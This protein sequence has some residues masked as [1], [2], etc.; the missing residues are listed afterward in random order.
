MVACGIVKKTDVKG[1]RCS[2]CEK[3]AAVFLPYA[4]TYLCRAHFF[5]HF[6]KA[7]FGTL[8]EFAMIKKG[9]KVAIGL[10]GGKDSVVLLSMLALLRKKLPYE[11]FAITMNLGI[12]C[13]Y[14][15]ETIRIAKEECARLGVRHYLFSL[16]DDFGYTLDEI[17]EKTG[18]RNPCS[19]CG[20][21]KRYLLNKHARE[22]GATK[23]AIAHTLNDTAETVMMNILRNEPLRLFRYNVHLVKDEK[24]V[25]RLKPFFRIPEDEVIAYGMLKN[26]PLLEKKCCPYSVFAFRKF[27]RRQLEDL[28][29]R[30]PGT[31]FRI[32]NSFLAMQKLFRL[33]G[34]KFRIK[35][36]VQCGEPSSSERC[37]FCII[38]EKLA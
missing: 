14:N 24:F 11:L 3:G 19:F 4:Q 17:V 26:L 30:Y 5:R 31:R 15:R 38:K 18:T 35:H 8:G 20:V 6:E 7:F 2:H 9:D 34:R 13:D 10:S 36:C 12:G 28:E 25:P 21:A 29:R 23:L 33:D 32:A 22:L 27:V 1:K 16:K 37:K